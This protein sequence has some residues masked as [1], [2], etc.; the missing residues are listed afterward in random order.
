MID[1]SAHLPGNKKNETQKQEEKRKERKVLWV[2]WVDLQ[3]RISVD[4]TLISCLIRPISTSG[5][6]WGYITSDRIQARSFSDRASGSCP[7]CLARVGD[8]LGWAWRTARPRPLA[9]SGQD[10]PIWGNFLVGF[11][12]PGRATLPLGVQGREYNQKN[13]EKNR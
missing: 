11:A 2:A 8:R 9:Q 1:K 10:R 3:G 12:A 4:L 7:P 6:C 5:G 13:R